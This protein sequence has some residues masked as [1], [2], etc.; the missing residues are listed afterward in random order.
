MAVA[1][2]QVSSR[3]RNDDGTQVTATWKS[4]AGSNWKQSPGQKFRVRFDI[5]ETGTTSG[6]I[7][8]QLRYSKNAAAY[9]S[10]TGSS[11]AIKAVSS[12][13]VTDGTATTQIISSGTFVAG[14]TDTVDGLCAATG[15]MAQ[16][17]HTELEFCLQ[18]VD[19]GVADGD[20]IDLRVYVSPTTALG[21]YTFT[22]RIT[23]SKPAL[24]ASMATMG[25]T[26]TKIPQ[27]PL[28]ASM[29]TFSAVATRT[30]EFA[31]SAISASMATM[32]GLLAEVH[33]RF[34]ALTASTATMAA[35][36][37]RTAQKVF[38]GPTLNFAAYLTIPLS[39][40]LSRQPQIPLSASTA[41]FS[42]TLVKSF[43]NALAASMA[44]FAGVL[45]TAHTFIKALT[46]SMATMAGGIVK[47]TKKFF[48]GS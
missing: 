21:T 4:A 36:I 29:A 9:T 26:I 24:T 30:F 13:N 35:T 16:S 14:S 23:V 33:Q 22:P 40:I 47:L 10:V 27:I 32:A 7:A 20:T 15:T 6:T 28:A 12:A 3:A 18:L 42:G 37:A 43:Q 5:S 8:G 41:V 25:A 48:T 46:A 31:R 17:T 34:V 45:A 44:T 11:A 38:V 1:W 19:G 39:G 2:T